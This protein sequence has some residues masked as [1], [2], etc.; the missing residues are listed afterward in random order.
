MCV[1]CQEVM[2]AKEDIRV[3]MPWVFLDV[4]PRERETER[5]FAAA[6]AAMQ[7]RVPVAARSWDVRRIGRKGTETMFHYKCISNWLTK[8][9]T[10]CIC[11]GPAVLSAPHFT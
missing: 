2:D 10:C 5:V 9:N 11:N 8:R 1:V 7:A 4:S 3:Q 6:E